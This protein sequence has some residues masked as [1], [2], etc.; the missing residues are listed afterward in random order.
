LNGG[1][2]VAVETVT[3]SAKYQVVIPKFIRD[4]LK[5]RP[6]QKI[7]AVAYGGRIELIP[8]RSIKELRGSLKGM[9]ASGLRDHEDRT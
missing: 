7:Q 6:G 2:E 9:D 3:V 1:K 4:Q 8:V 5:I